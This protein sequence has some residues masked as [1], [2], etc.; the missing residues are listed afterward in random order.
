MTTNSTTIKTNELNSISTNLTIGDTG[1]TVNL[2]ATSNIISLNNVITPSIKQK[3]YYFS[4]QT[5]SPTVADFLANG[6]ICISLFSSANPSTA[7]DIITVNLPVPTIQLEGT[8]FIFRKIRGIF[9][10]TTTNFIFN[11]SP[12]S[13]LGNTGTLTT[14]SSPLVSTASF[15]PSIHRIYVMAYLSTYVWA[16]A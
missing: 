6:T 3:V 10:N 12:A 5:F 4:T 1:S 16:F 15:N 2:G 13:I 14:G 11:S 8:Y 9:N 7:N